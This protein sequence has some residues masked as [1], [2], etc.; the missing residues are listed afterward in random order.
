[1]E[2]S[3]PTHEELA[4][5]A[6][7]TPTPTPDHTYSTIVSAPTPI[8]ILTTVISPYLLQPRFIQRL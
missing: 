4:M 3:M 1:M 6:A 8:P 7:T 2:I 5:A